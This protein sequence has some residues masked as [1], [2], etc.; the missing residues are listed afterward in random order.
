[1]VDL[2]PNINDDKGKKEIK[3]SGSV[4]PEGVLQKLQV[5]T[6]YVDK[7]STQYPDIVSDEG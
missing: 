4:N 7:T 2:Q 1:M 3:G 6:T 5:L